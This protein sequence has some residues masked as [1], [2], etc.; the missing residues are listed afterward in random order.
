MLTRRRI[1]LLNGED[2][3]SP[4]IDR[5]Q[6][7]LEQQGQHIIALARQQAEQILADAEEEAQSIRLRAQQ[8]AELDF[9]QQADTLLAG[10]QQQR[11]DMEADVLPVVESVLAQALGQL[12]TDVPESQRLSALL[13]QLLRE[14]IKADQEACTAI[15]HSR[16]RSPH[17]CNT[18]PIWRGNCSRMSRCSLTA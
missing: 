1:T 12:L 5:A 13:R 2:D 10:W 6:L 7:Q 4:V 18:M 16:R 14:K 17:G 3:L 15:P 9:W 8:Q 11:Q